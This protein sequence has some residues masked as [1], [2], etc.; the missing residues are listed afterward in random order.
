[1]EYPSTLTVKQLNA[2]HPE[3]ANQCATWDEI[4]L[5]YTGGNEI[6]KAASKFITKKPREMLDIYNARCN[7]FT[8]QNILGTVIGWYQ[9]SM[10]SEKPQVTADEKFLKNCDRAGTPFD[11]FLSKSFLSMLK[12]GCV[13]G[14]T[15]LP[16]IDAEYKSLADQKTAGA[17][18]P[19]VV[20]YTPQQ[21]IDWATDEYGKLTWV[22]IATVEERRSFAVNP[23][24][25]DRWYVFD[26]Q[27]CAVYECERKEGQPGEIAT[28]LQGYPRPH[29]TAEEN[30]VPVRVG[31][32]PDGLWLGNRMHL[33]ACTHLDLQNALHW[34][35]YQSCLPVLVVKGEYRDTITKE[36]VGF[37]HLD[38]DGSMEYCEPSGSSYETA[39]K[40]I[41]SVREELY[42]SAYVTTQGRSTEATPAAQSGY[43]KEVDNL[44]S[45]AALNGLGDALR[46]FAQGV[47]DDVAVASGK[48]DGAYTIRGFEFAD[49]DEAG[50]L[51]TA[52]GAK[53]LGIPSDT[54]EKELNK[55]TA[56]KLLDD[57][58]PAIIKKIEGEIDAAPTA[59]E[60]SKAAMEQQRTRMAGAFG[61]P[62]VAQG[63]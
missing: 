61:Q 62:P 40:E 8:Y 52:L 13:F 42:R 25:V 31:K 45:Q 10:F 33:G 63:T 23:V 4:D 18:D 24:T 44:P 11:D 54:L 29:A 55:R 37:V 27:T 9:A 50:A 35:M 2:K 12:Y 32:V 56:R 49:A 17:L 46:A 43:A 34:G 14:L 39:A 3:C 53:D 38:T 21:V 6:K 48:E 16:A 26:Q 59:E 7:R 58:D 47:L 28:L 15:D 60:R 36:E 19:Y 5:L 1:M 20:R 22:V 41:T 30:R 51:E 57:A